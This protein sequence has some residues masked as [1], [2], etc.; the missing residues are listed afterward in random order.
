MMKIGKQG[1]N[2]LLPIITF[3]ASVIYLTLFLMGMLADH[4]GY[5]VRGAIFTVILGGIFKLTGIIIGVIVLCNG[6]ER[7]GRNGF[8]LTVVSLSVIGVTYLVEWRGSLLSFLRLL[9]M[10]Y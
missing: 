1:Q 2:C 5:I 9:E 6:K 10:G 4:S 3:A 8:T 7:I